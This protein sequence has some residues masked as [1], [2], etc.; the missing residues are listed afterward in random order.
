M[1]RLKACQSFL[2]NYN[3]MDRKLPR[4]CN[5]AKGFWKGLLAVRKLAQ[6]AGVTEDD[7]K[8]WLMRQTIWYIYLLAPKH[9]LR[10][11]FDVESP[12]AV[13]QAGLLFLSRDRLSRGK[14]VFKYA[15]TLVDV[16]SRFKATGAIVKNLS[17]FLQLL[18][19]RQNLCKRIAQT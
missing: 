1:V 16:V 10:P 2:V 19:Q 3:E 14:K 18:Q 7:A 8:V 6:E 5:S 4:V 12:N 17:T 11:T 15:S 13:Y 9:I